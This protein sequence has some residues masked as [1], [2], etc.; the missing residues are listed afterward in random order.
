MNGVAVSAINYQQMAFGFLGGLGLFLFCI[1][2]MVE[3]IP[4][5]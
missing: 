3:A 4:I 1:K 5:R 2:Y